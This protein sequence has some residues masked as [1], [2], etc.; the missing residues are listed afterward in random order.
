VLIFTDDDCRLDRDY[1]VEMLAYDAADTGPVLR[2]G[3]VRLGDPLDLPL[4]VTAA[5]RRRWHK[6]ENPVRHENMGAFILGCNMTLRRCLAERL[7]PFDEALG[8]GTALAAGEDHDYILRAYC[9]GAAVECVPDMAVAHFH[10]RRTPAEGRKLIRGYMTGAGAVYAKYACKNPNLCR[11]A[12]WDCKSAAWET[13]TGANLFMPKLDFSSGDKLR[14]YV[15][16]AARYIFIRNHAG[17]R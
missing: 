17:T 12:Y 16:G 1:V 7:G 4:T 11:Q 8:A 13:L 3:H 9:A 10:G 6:G 14:C 15:R 2:G 5:A